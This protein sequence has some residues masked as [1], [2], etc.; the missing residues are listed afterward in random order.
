MRERGRLHA[1][2]KGGGAAYIGRRRGGLRVRREERLHHRHR[3]AAISGPVTGRIPD[4]YA[5]RR[6]EEKRWVRDETV[7]QM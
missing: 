4:L 3:G 7:E 6:G 5:V 2:R 1:A